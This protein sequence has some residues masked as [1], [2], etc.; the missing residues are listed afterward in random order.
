[1][2]TVHRQTRHLLLVQEE[3]LRQ[4]EARAVSLEAQLARQQEQLAVVAQ[5][6][7][8]AVAAAARSQAEARTLRDA[9]TAVTLAGPPTTTTSAT[10]IVTAPATLTEPPAVVVSTT[11]DGAVAALPRSV[12][13]EGEGEKEAAAETARL[14][15]PQEV[16]QRLRRDRGYDIAIPTPQMTA[17]LSTLYASL[18]SALQK[19]SVDIYS[20][21]AR[22]VLELIQN[23]DDNAYAA[24]VHPTFRLHLA[25]DQVRACGPART[26]TCTPVHADTL[27]ER[28]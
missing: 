19:L 17:C 15:A 28:H 16:V 5:E 13:E 26:P 14:Q 27:I 4:A 3:K 18:D 6:R 21:D 11:A 25:D 20:S 1:M 12:G 7:D 9:L 23:A 8:D 22:F 10:A 24:H 2:G